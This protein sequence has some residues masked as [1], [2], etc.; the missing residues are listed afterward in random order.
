MKINRIVVGILLVIFA[1]CANLNDLNLNKDKI[2]KEQLQENLEEIKI[3]LP[4]EDIYLDDTGVDQVLKEIRENWKQN[5]QREIILSKRRDNYEVYVGETLKIN[6]QDIS[7]IILQNKNIEKDSKI[8]FYSKDDAYYYRSIY[9]GN[10]KLEVKFIDGNTKIINIFN[11]MKFKFS[12]NDSYRIIIEKYNIGSYEQ[13]LKTLD[14]YKLSFPDRGLSKEIKILNIKILFE[15]KNYEEAKKDI[16][17]LK[18]MGDL[19]QENLME[20]LDMENELNLTGEKKEREESH[21]FEL[22]KKAYEKNRYNEAILY[23]N[24]V[25]EENLNPEKYYYIADSYFRIGNYEKSIENYKLYLNLVDSGIKK[26]EASYNIGLS[27]EKLGEIDQAINN[28]K[29]TIKNFP[30]TSWARKS[31]IYL[32]RLKSN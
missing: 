31:N 7:Y 5:I 25:L 15:T 8:E 2:K 24:R 21:F 1:G 22:G 23:L 3:E 14:L 17:N 11:K 10:T 26:A 29:E 9:Q 13:A 28:F 12:E 27:Y 32:V 20:I 30:G 16:E 18:I 4:Q 19:T 6:S